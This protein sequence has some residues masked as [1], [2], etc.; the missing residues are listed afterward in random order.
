[1]VGVR[2]LKDAP[3]CIEALSGIGYEYVPRL[4]RTLQR[5][6]FLRKSSA[7]KRTHHVHLIER[8]NHEWWDSHV[9]FR[10]YLRS[11]P[12]AAREYESLKR[13]LA[14][15]FRE[16]RDAHTTAKTS[17]ILEME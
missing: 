13:D 14:E 6:R 4:E 15:R 16:D 11:H 8:S 9:L 17:F 1:M 10:D 5:R 7:G 3:A 2:A 12:E